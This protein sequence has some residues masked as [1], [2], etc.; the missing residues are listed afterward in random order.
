[1]DVDAAISG[2]AGHRGLRALLLGDGRDALREM[3]G[4]MLGRDPAPAA[5]RLVR[6]HLKP[7]RKLTACY[8]VTLDGTGSTTPVAVTWF[9]GG[10]VAD[11]DSLDAAEEELRR[12]SL[13]T[14]FARLWATR[15]SW[16]MQVLAA[17]LDPAFPDLGDLSHPRRAGEVLSRCGVLPAVPE[18]GVQVRPIR[19]R[20]G[21]RHVLEYRPD[22]GPSLF[23]KLYRPGAGGSVA[24]A[25]G[26]LFDQLEAAAVP[27]VRAVHPAAV[28]GGGDA[29]LYLCAPGAPLSQ[30]LRAGR[31]PAPG[32]LHHVGLLLRAIHSSVP[33]PGSVLP[34]RDLEGEA[35]VVLRACEAMTALRPD[36]GAAA[37][38]SV[39]QACAGLVALEQEPAT[40]VHGDMKADH[41]LWGP[42]GLTVLD[43]DRCAFADPAFDLGK[44][45]ADV[46]WWTAATP[47]ADAAA[48]EAEI[49]AGYGAAGQRLARAQLYAALLLVR[50][51]ARRV[52]L[53]SRD[54]ASRTGGLLAL[55]GRAVEV[56]TAA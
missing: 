52:P 14:G 16:G 34:R 38:R 43:T 19:Y 39:E 13:P 21:Q 7:A 23:V 49:L 22:R 40:V 41:M 53:A 48:V 29:L 37:S 25:V 28:L 44:M 6:A 35:R 10:T 42:Q 33:G 46:R 12:A 11:A 47:R 4:S 5:C 27:R 45:L 30:R 18:G 1:M 26:T 36:L 51:A 56:R 8:D 54:W 55:A 17:P 20:P 15:P 3:L 24:G 31:P 2:Q 50:M 32:H 9:R